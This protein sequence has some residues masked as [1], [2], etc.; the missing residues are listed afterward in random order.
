[1]ITE[2]KKNYLAAA[3]GFS[4]ER[5][6]EIIREG[7]KKEYSLDDELALL[8]KEVINIGKKLSDMSGESIHSDEFTAYNN[9]VETVKAN[10]NPGE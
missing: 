2:S 3:T 7:V 6:I 5:R 9:Y 8:R 1:M 4:D 10:A